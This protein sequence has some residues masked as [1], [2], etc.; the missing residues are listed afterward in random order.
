MLECSISVFGCIDTILPNKCPKYIAN[1][2]SVQNNVSEKE[3]AAA[4]DLTFDTGPSVKVPKY[5][6]HTL[7]ILF[8]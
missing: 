3:C 6:L 5:S 2:Y 8:V 7:C 4:F 1:S